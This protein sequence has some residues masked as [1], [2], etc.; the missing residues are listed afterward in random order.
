VTNETTPG[1][2]T[3]VEKDKRITVTTCGPITTYVTVCLKTGRVETQ[4]FIKTTR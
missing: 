1:P 4:T 3:W 2:Q